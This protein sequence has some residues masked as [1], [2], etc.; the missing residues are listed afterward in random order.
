MLAAC[1]QQAA[2]SSLGGPLLL[3][4][5]LGPLLKGNLRRT[6]LITQGDPGIFVE[7]PISLVMLTATAILA[8]MILPSFRKTREAAF[9]EEDA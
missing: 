4:F 7:R 2:G 5:V 8:L 9:Q 3:G 6:L 1:R